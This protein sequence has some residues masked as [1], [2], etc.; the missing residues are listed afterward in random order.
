MA[1]AVQAGKFVA[2]SRSWGSQRTAARA[3]IQF[4]IEC[5]MGPMAKPWRWGKITVAGSALV[6]AAMLTGCSSPA[7]I[8]SIPTALGGLPEGVPQR[9]ATPPAYPAVHDTPPP[10]A[11][12]TLSEAERIRLRQDLIT[13]RQKTEQIVPAEATGST[14]GAAPKP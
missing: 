10:R 12:A 5:V 14:A 9:P 8:D 11:D 4:S 2:I 3:A 1:R 6:A 7:V 13:T